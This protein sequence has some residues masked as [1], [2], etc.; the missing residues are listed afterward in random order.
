MGCQKGTSKEW[1]GKKGRIGEWGSD[2]EQCIINYMHK[3]SQEN[4][5]LC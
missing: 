2:Y 5:L 4:I 3:I 1:V